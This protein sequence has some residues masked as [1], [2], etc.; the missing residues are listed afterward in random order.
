MTNDSNQQSFVNVTFQMWFHKV[1]EN[2]TRD[3]I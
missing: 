2:I 3:S 1:A